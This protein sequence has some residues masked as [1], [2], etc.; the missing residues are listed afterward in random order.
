MP[1]Y[2][3]G[4]ILARNA[5]RVPTDAVGIQGSAVRVL[6]CGELGAIVGSIERLPA[7]AT[8]EDVRAHDRVLQ[9]IVDN[10]LTA[11]AVRF[12]Q[13]FAND[14][15]VRRHV[16]ERAE[17]LSRVLEEYDGCVEMRLLLT[18]PPKPS[19]APVPST[20]ET[21]DAGR[22]SAT[23]GPGRAYLEEV[24]SA[25]ERT[26]RLALRGALGPVVRA[27]RVEELPKSRGVAFSHLIRRSEEAG[28]REAVA[29]LPALGDARVVGPLALYSFAE[30]AQ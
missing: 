30:P 10:G 19:V 2:L 12:G 14:D 17:Q 8:L 11:A 13:S 5:S 24:K 3:Y 7:R 4:L 1:S 18:H 27:E 21:L 23:I 9:A 28:Y 6:N 26:E 25:G 16:I 22:W 29:A 20:Q 15:D